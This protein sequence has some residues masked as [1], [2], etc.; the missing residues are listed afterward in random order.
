MTV[1]GSGCP[2][3]TASVD[4]APDRTAFTVTYS[5]YLAQVGV[6]AGPT[7]FR[8]NCQ[9]MVRVNAPQGFTYGI[10]KADYRGY[11]SLASGAWARERANYYFQ[12]QSQTASIPHPFYGPMNDNWHATDAT[13]VGSIVYA[14]CGA[15]RDLAINTQLNVGAGSSNPATTTS[16]M[17]IDSTDGSLNTIYHLSWNQCP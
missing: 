13:P 7:D 8:K 9:I 1:N 11:A 2:A 4:P 10:A 6:G 17:T 12:G 14:P 15:S 3:G 16:F 5:D